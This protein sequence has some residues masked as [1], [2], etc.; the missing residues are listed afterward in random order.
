MDLKII[1]PPEQIKV[2]MDLIE[3]FRIQNKFVFDITLQLDYSMSESAGEYNPT[4]PNIIKVNPFACADDSTFSYIEDNTLF[5]AIMH[6]F[7][8]FLSMTYFVD[9]QKNYLE[10]FPENRF[11]ITKYEAANEDYDEE[12]AEIFSCFLRVPYLLKL[13]S[14]DHYRFLRSWCISPVSCTVKRFVYMYNRL[15][16]KYKNKLRTKWGIIVN[17]AEQKVYKINK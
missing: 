16:V 14:E 13:V 3:K 17:H 10:V 9:F 8:H 7:G 4:K 15:P 2:A 1:H 12:I 11:L 5:G 6:E